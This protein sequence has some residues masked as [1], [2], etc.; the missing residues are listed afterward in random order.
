MMKK[1]FTTF[2]LFQKSNIIYSSEF[3]FLMV[4]KGHFSIFFV[5]CSTISFTFLW[6]LMSQWCPS[7]YH[8]TK[9]H[10]HNFSNLN[11][12]YIIFELYTHIPLASIIKITVKKMA[13]SPECFLCCWWDLQNWKEQS[14][15]LTTGMEGSINHPYSAIVPMPPD[16]FDLVYFLQMRTNNCF[17]LCSCDMNT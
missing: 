3:L 15:T 2:F 10:V 4:L 16:I 12:M 6:M 7:F 17:F 11:Y 14:F 13:I 5:L 9:N 8:V 1:D